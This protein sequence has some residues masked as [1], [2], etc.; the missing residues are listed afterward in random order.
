MQELRLTGSRRTW[1]ENFDQVTFLGPW[2]YLDQANISLLDILKTKTVMGPWKHPDAIHEADEYINDLVSRLIPALLKQSTA[3]SLNSYSYGKLALERSLSLWLIHWLSCL[4]D[5]YTSLSH[6]DAELTRPYS[7]VVTDGPPREAQDTSLN[8][9]VSMVL[10][11]EYNLELMS[12]LISFFKWKN[13]KVKKMIPP[14]APSTSTS[15][16][17]FKTKV[18]NYIED[19]IISELWELGYINGIS[20]LDKLKLKLKVDSKLISKNQ[21]TEDEITLHFRQ[22]DELLSFQP[23][24]LFETYIRHAILK[25]IPDP[26]LISFASSDVGKLWI[27]ADLFADIKKQ[28]RISGLTRNGKWFDVQHGGGYGLMRTFPLAHSE[29]SFSNGFINW[30][31]Q[32]HGSYE[33]NFLP[34]PSPHLSKLPRRNLNAKNLIFVSTQYPHYLFR[35]HSAPLPEAVLNAAKEPVLFFSNLNSKALSKSYYRPYPKNYI[36]WSLIEQVGHKLSGNQILS[37]KIRPSQ[38]L[39]MSRL[40]V[41]QSPQTTFLEALASDVPVI[42]IFNSQV[43]QFSE[44]SQPYIEKMRKL[45]MV[46]DTPEAAADFING[47]W[48]EEGE[49][50]LDAWWMS[51]ELCE[52]KRE[53]CYRYARRADDWR[54]QWQ[55]F[56]VQELKN[57]R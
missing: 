31:W 7:V 21:Q 40:V 27:G 46:F 51:S 57:L 37:G 41:V 45:H 30:G 14:V 32:S 42:G 50:S 22:S 10:D 25:Q 28:A 35:F 53:F 26:I 4:Y 52:L 17:A 5:R 16:A 12:D 34:L 54:Q 56:L 36:G 24:N 15:K 47:R 13:F 3:G 33:G 6:L 44:E 49:N 9:I 18:K 39:N 20:L 43:Y 11:H 2:C 38:I 55:Q 1:S 48:N 29:Y 23:G 8:N 19:K